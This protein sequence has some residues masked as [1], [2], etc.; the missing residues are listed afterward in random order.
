M[1]LAD[2]VDLADV[3]GKTERFTGAHPGVAVAQV[4]ALAGDVHDM[5]GLAEIGEL[6]CTPRPG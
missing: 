3:A 6:L 2:D 1:P 4:P 5:T